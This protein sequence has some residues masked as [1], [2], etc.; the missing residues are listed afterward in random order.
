MGVHSIIPLAR[1]HGGIAQLARAF[2][3][4]PKCRWFKSDCRYQ[5]GPVVKR[6]RHRPFTAVT[7]VRF[8]SGSPKKTDPQMRPVVSSV[9]FLFGR[10]AQLV[11]AFASH[12]RGH[13]FESPCVHHKSTVILIELRWTFSMPE[14]RLK[15]RLL[16]FLSINEPRRRAI[17]Q[18]G[19]VLY[20]SFVAFLSL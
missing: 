12:A 3:S 8:S 13:G 6:L 18:R 16:P 1:L 20:M 11:R 2:G 19:F 7:R 9:G 14:K 4:Y 5:F 10:I 17:L 15:S